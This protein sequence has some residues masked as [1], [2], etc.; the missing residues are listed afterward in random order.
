MTDHVGFKAARAPRKREET[1]QRDGRHRSRR[2]TLTESDLAELEA[3]LTEDLQ[4]SPSPSIAAEDDDSEQSEQP[5]LEPVHPPMPAA[6]PLAAIRISDWPELGSDHES[7]APDFAQDDEPTLVPAHLYD[8]DDQAPAHDELSRAHAPAREARRAPRRRPLADRALPG[9]EPHPD[10]RSFLARSIRAAATAFSFGALI[11]VCAL[12]VVL[13]IGGEW[14]LPTAEK[15]AP[16]EPATVAAAIPAAPASPAKRDD[17]P[18]KRDD[19]PAVTGSTEVKPDTSRVPPERYA[20]AGRGMVR[21]ADTQASSQAS[22][23]A[24]RSPA[25]AAPEPRA[26]D[27]ALAS[28]TPFAPPGETAAETPDAESLVD[29]DADAPAEPAIQSRDR[30]AEPAAATRRPAPTRSAATTPTEAPTRNAAA[31]R[32]APVTT[33]VNM[34]A[35]ADNDAAVV[36]VVPAGKNVGIVACSQ[37]CEVVYNEKQGFI[38]GRFV[39]G[40]KE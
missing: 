3:L 13:T 19:A 7:R 26:A 30:I 33:H 16:S 17:A 8:L 10:E 27:T 12:L 28:T 39:K 35:T 32:N 40:A 6:R 37:W 4:R 38:H 25:P 1:V 14:V 23:Q 18:A 21:A 15:S 29:E 9:E 31:T 5:V 24:E 34:R 22:Q 11:G 2:A 20:A 36:A